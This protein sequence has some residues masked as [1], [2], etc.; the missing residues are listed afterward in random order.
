MAVFNGASSLGEQLQSLQDQ[1]HR[2]WHLLASDDGSCD[3][4]LAK[5][6]DFAAETQRIADETGADVKVTSLKGPGQGAAENF[7]SL[8]RKLPEHGLGGGWIAFSDQDD[9][10]LP[11]RLSRGLAAL[12]AIDETRPALYCSRSWI[13]D[14]SLS[15]RRLS[16]S[17]PRSAGFRNALV[18]NIVSGN[19]IL[20]NPA[21]ALLVTQAAA[22]VQQVVVHDWW[23]YQLV[24]GVNGVVVHDDE[25]TLLYRQHGVNQIGAN[26]T[27][28]ARL[29]RIGQLLRG[30]FRDWNVI[31]VAALRCSAQAFPPEHRALLDDFAQLPGLRFDQ[32][33]RRLARLRLYRQS[34][35]STIALWLA[36]ALNKL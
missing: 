13:T 6:Q 14:A 7:M 30:D 17:R 27:F 22:N 15:K 21:A 26:D 18:Q 31:N 25:P 28:R 10:W 11:D 16:A 35:S 32:R 3:N 24:T 33:L 2:R 12:K 20:L 1:T 5:I 8:L 34:I 29:K 9:V 36:A 4:S 23:V 19:T